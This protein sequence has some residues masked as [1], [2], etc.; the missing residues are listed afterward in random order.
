VVT[1]PQTLHAMAGIWSVRAARARLVTLAQARAREIADTRLVATDG[2]QAWRPSLGRAGG[3]HADPV[4]GAGI[5]AGSR[6]APVNEH[7]QLLT[8]DAATLE[9]LADA[10]HT[11]LGADPLARL[12][13]ATPRP[14]AAVRFLPW[15]VEIDTRARTAA[16]MPP[17]RSPLPDAPPCPACGRLTLAART[18]APD[19]R[20]WTVV[21]TPDCLC[22]GAACPE[23]ATCRR[24]KP[25]PADVPVRDGGCPCGMTVRA[26]DVAHIWPTSA[27]IV[28]DATRTHVRS[29]L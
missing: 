18:A 15:L 7:Q 13:S 24:C 1:H 8:R 22:H 14:S 3:V 20:H 10:L 26:R 27:P 29:P 11:P 2:L 6:P 16:G 9:W 23:V 17:D 19:S 4:G 21:C 28:A 5:A 25:G 12:L